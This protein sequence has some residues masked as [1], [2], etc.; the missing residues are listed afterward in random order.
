MS[1]EEKEHII[2][3]VI[4]LTFIADDV[5]ESV[6][7]DTRKRLSNELRALWDEERSLRVFLDMLKSETLLQDNAKGKASKGRSIETKIHKTLRG[8]LDNAMLG[9][10]C[11]WRSI[12]VR[13]I[14]DHI[15]GM[16]DQE[17]IS[18]YEKLYTGVMELV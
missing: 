10:I 3:Q 14:C 4:S 2:A 13:G 15:A 11:V 18:E 8:I 16:T 7:K 6:V 12:L 1:N 5:S 9:A 17:A